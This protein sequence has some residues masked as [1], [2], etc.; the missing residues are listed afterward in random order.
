M[1]CLCVSDPPKIEKF[2]KM[3]FFSLENSKISILPK[4]IGYIPRV[5]SSVPSSELG[6]PTPSPASESAPR[7]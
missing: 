4:Y 3:D 1:Q 6:P 5:S 2:E 7:N